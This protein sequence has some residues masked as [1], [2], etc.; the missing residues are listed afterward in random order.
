MGPEFMLP[1]KPKNQIRDSELIK[2]NQE[3]NSILFILIV[4]RFLIVK[5]REKMMELEFYNG[6]IM[7]GITKLG[8]SMTQKK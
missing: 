7:V 5:V 6:N 4:E 2:G 8:D 1:P 3:A